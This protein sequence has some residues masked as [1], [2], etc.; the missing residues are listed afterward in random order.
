MPE[1]TPQPS[2]PQIIRPNINQTSKVP[3][4]KT[5]SSSSVVLTL[6]LLVVGGI[7]GFFV[8]GSITSYLGQRGQLG[9][10]GLA[11]SYYIIYPIPVFAVLN[12]AAYRGIKSLNKGFKII[13]YLSIFIITLSVVFSALLIYIDFKESSEEIAD[14]PSKVD[15]QIYKPSQ[16]H[17]FSSLSES[18]VPIDEDI[19]LRCRGVIYTY[20]GSTDGF[21]LIEM[22]ANEQGCPDLNYTN[23][24]DYNEALEAAEE[25]TIFGNNKK[26][27]SRE[28]G[29]ETILLVTEDKNGK[30]RLRGIYGI[31]GTTLIVIQV[32]NCALGTECEDKFIELYKSLE[33]I[34][35]S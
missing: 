30:S 32:G 15:F 8:G 31:K 34:N 35:S 23:Q 29:N 27:I 17:P 1:A 10:V 5:K 7:I 33:L 25:N 19:E 26:V 12:L 13:G 6:V 20:F 3:W 11:S 9:D 2:N 18:H 22:K 21:K 16:N 28:V 24:E 14:I 4:Q